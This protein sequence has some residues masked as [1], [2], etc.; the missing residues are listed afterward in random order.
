MRRSAGFGLIEVLVALVILGVG[1][2]GLARLQL[3]MLAGVADT[4]AYDHAVRLANDQLEALRLTR[5]VEGVPAAGSD[6]RL[7]QGMVFQRAWTI[8]CSADRLCRAAVVVRWHEPRAGSTNPQRA[9]TLEA[10]LAPPSMSSQAWLVQS[11][12]P[13]REILP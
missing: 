10:V 4:A 5:Q 13:G 9:I 3:S 6:E 8:A 2:M 11:G 12:S 7:V 1:L